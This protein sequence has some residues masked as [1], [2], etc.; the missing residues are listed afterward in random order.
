MKYDNWDN[1]ISNA[2]TIVIIYSVLLIEK[3]TEISY[4]E[5]H[6]SWV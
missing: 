4:G 2:T 6:I 3:N 1:F 5:V